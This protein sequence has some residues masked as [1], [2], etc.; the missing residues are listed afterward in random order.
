MPL[1]QERLSK[2]FYLFHA[3]L[4]RQ[5]SLSNEYDEGSN[6]ILSGHL[7]PP[8]SPT[9][10]VPMDYWRIPWEDMFLENVIIAEGNFGQVIKATIKRG[11]EPIEAAVKILKG[12]KRA[13]YRGIS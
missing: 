7:S 8:M 11:N 4:M 3:Q 10:S 13:F 12:T 2:R 5:R 1:Q 6:S 9:S